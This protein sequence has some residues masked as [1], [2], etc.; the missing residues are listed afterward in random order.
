MPQLIDPETPEYAKTRTGIDNYQYELVFS[1]E[2]NTDG[3]T[4][5]PGDDPF[6]EAVDLN[7]WATKDY[8]WYDPSAITTTNGSL[9]ITLDAIPNHD[10]WYRSG[11][12]QTW[13]K[14]CFTNGYLEGMGEVYS[15]TLKILLT[16]PTVSVVF[17]GDQ[18]AQGFVRAAK[19][20][21]LMTTLIPDSLSGLPLGRW[22]ILEG[23]ATARQPTG[24]GHTRES[25][26]ASVVP[27][28]ASHLYF[29]PSARYDSCDYGT[30]PNQTLPNGTP[31]AA[32]TGGKGGG[33]L[34]YL[35]GQ[36]ASYVFWPKSKSPF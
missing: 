34:S 29:R 4:F 12:L 25:L 7:Y 17:P 13:N 26:Y 3:R 28:T 19:P 6:W 8:E 5:Y 21:A 27:T 23:R 10:L 18:N 36:R 33:P 1:D 20:C 9:V 11:M 30:L 16:S 31:A 24:C 35:P 14:F 2:F 15:R 32:A 22:E